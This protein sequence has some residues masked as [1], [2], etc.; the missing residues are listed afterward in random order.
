MEEKGSEQPAS[1][2]DVSSAVLMTPVHSSADTKCENNE[3]S[4]PFPLQSVPE[5]GERVSTVDNDTANGLHQ[6][7]PRW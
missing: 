3:V 2:P 5:S 7:V 1:A 6:E 4:V